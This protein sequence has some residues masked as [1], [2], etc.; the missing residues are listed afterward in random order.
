VA[1][2][3]PVLTLDGCTVL[4]RDGELA[5]HR[6]AV[7]GLGP[8]P[9]VVD[10]DADAEHH[11]RSP[12]LDRLDGLMAD[13][14][15][16]ETG[17]IAPVE[18]ASTGGFDR[19]THYLFRY[20]AKF[21]PPIVRQ[22]L[23]KYTEI[24]QTVLD[25]FCGSGTLLVE[26]VASG[27]NAIGIDVDPVAVAVTA[28][29]AHRYEPSKLQA[30]ADLLLFKIQPHERS[31]REYEFRMYEDMPE[32][33]YRREAQELARLIPAIPNLRHW[34]RR[35][36]ILDLARLRQAIAQIDVPTTHRAFLNIVFASIIR[37]SS[38]ADPVPV[39]GLE[40]TSHMKRIDEK[41]RLIN[42][43]E[44]FRSS[45]RKALKAAAEFYR[46][47]SPSVEVRVHQADAASLPGRLVRHVHTVITSPPYHGAV[48]YYRRHQLEMFWL[49][50]TE[51]QEARLRLLKSYIGRPK[52]AHS[53][54]LLQKASIDTDLAKYWDA[55]IRQLAPR[56]ADAFR[57]YIASMSLVFTRLAEVLQPGRL[58]IFI[59]GHSTWNG[60][61]IPTTELFTEVARGGFSIESVLTYPV[62]N[63]YMS[64]SRHNGADI[65]TE[66]ILVMRRTGPETS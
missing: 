25:P 55:R 48:D 49:G 34:F 50:L 29:K 63:R 1:P 32:R 15:L 11:E 24:G 5:G 10:R 13:H 17:V 22:L 26:A 20:P 57:H 60:T 64:Y 16:N 7:S 6:G 59:V 53:D 52:V 43:F 41:G 61:E 30:S 3:P 44:L 58:A 38:N 42:P 39:S 9:A 33:R 56:R 23:E 65:S 45:L 18:T 47:T 27:R 4:D 31:A 36:V 28:A 14:P 2:A 46:A 51:N 54:P 19:L 66:Y 62:K 8:E 37:N 40:V 12:D 35:Y 21:H